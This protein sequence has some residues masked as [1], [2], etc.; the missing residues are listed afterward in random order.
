MALAYRTGR[1]DS[2]P[3]IPALILVLAAVA[4]RI[5]TGLFIQSGA[6]WLCNFAPLAAV[7]LCSAA[8]FPARLKFSL[9]LI[10]LF[11]SDVILNIHYG[12]SLL[13]AHIVSRYLALTIVGAVGLLLQN[14]ASLKTLLPA[15]IASS[16]IF[17][18][19]TNAFS[20]LSDPGYM[21]NM[22]GL[23]QALTVGLPQYSSTPTWMF[24]R[25]SLVSDLAFTCLFVM[26]VRLSRNA[27]EAAPAKTALAR[28]A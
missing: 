6:T 4:Y 22:A 12:A 25:N 26:C 7:A 3:M 28:A 17:Y 11:L 23:I 13:D 16:V 18:A 8:Y 21:K 14:R 15:S 27:T 1:I 24:F 10:A 2:L 9:P 20:W 19:I 5:V